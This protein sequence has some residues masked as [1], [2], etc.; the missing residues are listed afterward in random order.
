M[1]SADYDHR[2][3]SKLYKH[4]IS[5]QQPVYYLFRGIII[6]STCDILYIRFVFNLFFYNNDNKQYTT[7]ILTKLTTAKIIKATLTITTIPTTIKPTKHNYNN[8]NM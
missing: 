5:I 8:H 6:A 7:T 3:I 2:D 4:I 1:A